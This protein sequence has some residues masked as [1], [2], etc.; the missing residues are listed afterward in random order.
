MLVFMVVLMKY[1]LKTFGYIFILFF[2]SFVVLA[3]E[4][5]EN[6]QISLEVQNKINTV[7]DKYNDNLKNILL[8][9]NSLDQAQLEIMKAKNSL[10][11]LNDLPFSID[12]Q[13]LLLDEISSSL[14]SLTNLERTGVEYKLDLINDIKENFSDDNFEASKNL[15]NLFIEILSFEENIK[16]DLNDIKEDEFSL[17]KSKIEEYSEILENDINQDSSFFYLQNKINLDEIN[18]AKLNSK[19]LIFEE[20]IFDLI[21]NERKEYIDNINLIFEIDE[22][23]FIDPEIQAKMDIELLK[24]EI[25]NAKLILDKTNEDAKNNNIILIDNYNKLEKLYKAPRYGEYLIT[26]DG[27][28]ISFN[29]EETRIKESIL[30]LEQNK[31]EFQKNIKLLT[32]DLIAKDEKVKAIF[33]DT[34]KLNMEELIVEAAI[35]R[36]IIEND[37]LKL[38]LDNANKRVSTKD[39]DLVTNYNDLEKLYNS[40]RVG[41][42]I[43]S[44]NGILISFKKEEA[45]IKNEIQKIEIEKDKL[46][47]KITNLNKEIKNK[48]NNIDTSKK[49]K[50]IQSKKYLNQKKTFKALHEIKNKLEED[51]LNADNEL[52]DARLKGDINEINRAL[53]KKAFASSKLQIA[54]AEI[55]IS[56]NKDRKKMLDYKID[57]QLSKKFLTDIQKNIIKR[58]HEIA[59]KKIDF[60]DKKIKTSLSSRIN[61]AKLDQNEEMLL[62]EFNAAEKELKEARSEGDINKINQ[63]LKKKAL[64]SSKLQITRA[65]IAISKNKEKS[66]LLEYDRDLKISHPLLDI[67]TKQSIEQSY[68][69]SIKK[70]ELINNKIESDINQENF[71]AKLDQNE[72]M[73]LEEFNAAEKELKEARSEG[74]INKINQALKKKALA[75]S[76]LQITRAEIAISKNKEKSKLLEYDRDLKLSFPSLT[77]KQRRK[78]HG[79]YTIS[80]DQ[81]NNEYNSLKNKIRNSINERKLQQNEIEYASARNELDKII[82]EGDENKINEAKKLLELSEQKLLDGQEEFKKFRDTFKLEA[83]KLEKENL[84]SKIKDMTNKIS[85]DEKKLSEVNRKVFIKSGQVFSNEYKKVFNGPSPKEKAALLKRIKKGSSKNVNVISNNL[86]ILNGDKLITIPMKDIIG[87]TD[88]GLNSIIIAAFDPNKSLSE[89]KD[90]FNDDLKSSIEKSKKNNINK[91]NKDETKLDTETQLPKNLKV[92][93]VQNQIQSNIKKVIKTEKAKQIAEKAANQASKELKEAK[94]ALKKAAQ[95]LNKEAYQ[96]ALIALEDAKKVVTEKTILALEA[97]SKA[98]QEA[99]DHATA[100]LKVETQKAIKNIALNDLLQAQV[101]A[102]AKEDAQKLAQ[103][104]LDSLA[105]LQATDPNKV[106][107]QNDLAV[108][109]A[110]KNAAVAEEDAK[111][112]ILNEAQNKLNIL[113]DA[114]NKAKKDSNEAIEEKS[115]VDNDLDNA[116]MLKD[117]AEKE[118]NEKKKLCMTCK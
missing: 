111:E 61:K 106:A 44:K 13:K 76:K 32:K 60:S 108:K 70:L 27:S 52:K 74:D 45:R 48:Q 109:T 30:N 53:E 107:A 2:I 99:G 90:T 116:N 59:S 75:S 6:V 64:A 15:E 34:N 49:N 69:N 85:E 81:L 51:L 18:K 78:I 12:Q 73:L 71:K 20:D 114:S 113:E 58:K 68:N 37:E 112:A 4:A 17:L 21:K 29:Q 5:L 57:I 23:D 72:E 66:K 100:K 79:N 110:A 54:R 55:E 56:K 63:A 22:N 16:S 98:A 24:D 8:L 84:V 33:N 86:L 14:V 91:Q 93:K 31:S 118:V 104:H 96:K 102:D 9:K 77:L 38:E 26:S 65:E 92:R 1:L 19:I 83:L 62:E 36:L 87:Q 41:D 7:E 103:D 11:L 10:V 3:Q 115:L 39:K 97:A 28:L 42:Y 46:S 25:D 88:E 67:E 43:L 40:N 47:K 35:N 105:T 50:F 94:E 82:E 101:V 95:S 80:V 117:K 89:I